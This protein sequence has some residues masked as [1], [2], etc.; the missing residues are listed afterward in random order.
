MP[1]KRRPRHNLGGGPKTFEMSF[2]VDVIADFSLRAP[3]GEWLCIENMDKR[4]PIGRTV[5][6]LD[7]IFQ[8]LQQASFC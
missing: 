1:T 6:E 8:H 4:K 2:L 5:A 3:F 7:S